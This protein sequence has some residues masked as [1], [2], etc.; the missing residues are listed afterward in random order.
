MKQN[1]I[2]FV[3]TAV[4]GAVGLGSGFIIGY[5]L[6]GPYHKMY[7]GVQSEGEQQPQH[8]LRQRQTADDNNNNNN[9]T[10]TAARLNQCGKTARHDPAIRKFLIEGEVSA[11]KAV[12]CR[13]D[14]PRVYT[15]YKLDPNTRINIDGQLGDTAWEQVAW[16]EAFVDIGGEDLPAPR[17]ESRVKLRWDD[18]TLYVGAYLQELAVWANKTLHDSTIYQD[19]S[20]QILLDTAQSNHKYKEIS[21][22]AMGTV[23]DTMLTR[24]YMDDGEPLVFW[25]S[26]MERAVHIEG[27]LNDPSTRNQYWTVEMAIPFKNLYEGTATHSTTPKDR[28][29]WRANF[30]RAE[31][32]TDIVGGKYLKRVDAATDW[33]VW[34]SLGVANIHLPDRW[35]L[36]Q[37]V[38][39]PVNS[40]SFQPDR[41]WLT[42]NALLDVYRAEKAYKAVTGKYSAKKELLGLPPYVLSERCI[43]D[44]DIQL[45]WAGF[46]V[47]ARSAQAFPGE[48]SGHT[49]T[50]R[51]VWFGEEEGDYFR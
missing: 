44:L 7:S 23:A 13:V 31:W 6:V 39:A 28:E 32:K 37:F 42:T 5:L 30:V 45:D 1:T 48:A 46:R 38:T 34:Q 20:F 17:F 3:I 50:D 36:L 19:N 40:T 12:E 24:P 10:L 33:W 41:T 21:I 49:R 47:T 18:S 22:N 27:P 15:V 8:H 4:I 51:L 25:E 26:E 9:A 35:G 29:T 2:S 11:C 43:R 14:L 16:T